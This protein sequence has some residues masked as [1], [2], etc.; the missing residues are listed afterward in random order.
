ME[1][2]FHIFLGSYCMPAYFVGGK[3]WSEAGQLLA[4]IF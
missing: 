3:I 1:R 4:F 2:K